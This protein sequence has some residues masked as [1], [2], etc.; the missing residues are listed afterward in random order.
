MP[1]PV[2]GPATAPVYDPDRETATGDLARELSRTEYAQALPN[3]ILEFLGRLWDDFVAWVESLNALAPNLGWLVVLLVLAAVVAAIVLF[4]RPRWHR[5]AATPAA[6]GAPVGLDAALGAEAYRRRA[7]RALLAADYATSVLER[8]RA[9]VARAEER[10]L[11]DPQPGRTATEVSAALGRAFGAD[12]GDLQ[13]AAALFNAV[14]Y[15]HHEP[16]PGDARW[17]A[18]L[19]ERLSTAT[20]SDGAAPTLAVPR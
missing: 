1:L 8:F 16:T 7:D 4:V 18:G 14:H 2:P 6:D 15:G 9:L 19:E 11:L 5:T 20:A 13:Q 10:T 3:P 17:L 12:A